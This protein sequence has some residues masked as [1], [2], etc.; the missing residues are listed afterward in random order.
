MRRKGDSREFPFLF[1]FVRCSPVVVR[2]KI[3]TL[4]FIVTKKKSEILTNRKSKIGNPK[5][6]YVGIK[7]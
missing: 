6:K 5:S 2:C 7:H 3:Y 1:Y 4:N